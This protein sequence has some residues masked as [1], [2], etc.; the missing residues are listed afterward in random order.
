MFIVYKTGEGHREVSE[1]PGAIR[2]ESSEAKR[3]LIASILPKDIE[4]GPP[5]IFTL[6]IHVMA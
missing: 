1:V 6:I 2:E 3:N 4:F 5:K